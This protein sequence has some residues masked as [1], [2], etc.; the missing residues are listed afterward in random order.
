MKLGEKV[1]DFSVQ[2][3]EKGEIKKISL[4]D[5]K[6]KWVVLFYYVRDFTGVCSSEIGAFSHRI[7]EFEDLDA[8]VLGASTDSEFSHQ[9]WFQKEFPELPYPV[10]ADTTQT[11]ARSFGILKE[12]SGLAYRGTFIIDLEGVLRYQS[13]SDL[14]IGRSVEEILR[15]L[16]A[17]QTGGMCPADWKPGDKTL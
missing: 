13:I 11:I 14:P 10:I 5:Y 4:S 2:A 17:L 3:V 16:K 6:G 15:V 9:A 1:P 7:K 12:D 8:V